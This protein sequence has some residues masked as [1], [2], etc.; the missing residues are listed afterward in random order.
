MYLLTKWARL[1]CNGCSYLGAI[2]SIK[3]QLQE[4]S[5]IMWHEARKQEKKIREVMVDFQR[6]AERRREHYDKM[7]MI[8]K[9]PLCLHVHMIVWQTDLYNRTGRIKV[10][11]FLTRFHGLYMNVN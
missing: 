5:D 1:D 10:W 6:R 3:A 9:F 11:R 7:V 4:R 2:I 8:L